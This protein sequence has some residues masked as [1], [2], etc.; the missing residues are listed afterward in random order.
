MYIEAR[1][2]SFSLPLQLFLSSG[3]NDDEILLVHNGLL[4]DFFETKILD[5]LKNVPTV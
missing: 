2:L 5:S 4:L 3:Y 1:V